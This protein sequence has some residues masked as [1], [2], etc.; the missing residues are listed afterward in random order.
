MRRLINV[1]LLLLLLAPMSAHADGLDLS[2]YKGKVVY[3]DFWAS[4]CIPCRLSFPF[5]NDLQQRYESRGL[6]VVAVDVDKDRAAADDFLRQQLPGFKIVYDPAGQIAS[7]YKF[8]DMPTTVLIG[9]DGRQRFVHDGFFPAQ[10]GNY[11][12]HL[13]ALLREGSQQ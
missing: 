11:I 1:F 12:A 13:E 9:R 3:L 7:Q 6:V 5:M 8:R 10:E 4:W 2:A